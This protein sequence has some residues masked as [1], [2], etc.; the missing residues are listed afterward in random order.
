MTLGCKFSELKWTS[1][2]YHLKKK[3]KTNFGTYT[4]LCWTV[5]Q[6]D[7]DS[8]KKDFRNHENG[9]LLFKAKTNDFCSWSVWTFYLCSKT[10]KKSLSKH[11]NGS[12]E[13]IKIDG[14]SRKNFFKH[15]KSSDVMKYFVLETQWNWKITFLKWNFSALR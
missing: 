6:N 4:K 10:S 9:I 7:I 13:R 2:M 3:L 1:N 5:K 8:W 11:P 15:F 14:F 12:F